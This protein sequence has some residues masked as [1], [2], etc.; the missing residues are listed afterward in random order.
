MPASKPQT[1][2]N[3][4]FPSRSLV[5]RFAG[6]ARQ[7]PWVLW[8]LLHYEFQGQLGWRLNRRVYPQKS[9][10]PSYLSISPT[11]RC[12]LKCRMCIQHR[13]G[14]GTPG[15]ITWYK[16]DQEL[17]L[18]AWV[19][20]FEELTTW[21]PVVFITGG[22]PLLYPHILEF[23]EG[24]KKR[25]LLVHLQTNG[26]LLEGMAPHLVSLG[27]EMVTVSLDGPAEVHNRI[28]GAGTFQRSAQGLQALKEARARQ[29][30]PGPILD[31]RCT[32]S[33]DNL[34]SLGRMAAV[35]QELGADM[36]QF[37]HTIFSTPELVARHNRLLSPAWAH[38]KGLEIIAPSIPE[39]EFYESQIGPGDL[40]L[41]AASLQELRQQAR[42]R[43][44]ITFSPNLPPDLLAPYYL[45]LAYPFPQACKSLWKNCRILPDGTVSPCL[46]L[47]MGKITNEPLRAVWN[48]P[49]MQR[50]RHLISRGLLPGCV[51]C[52]HRS[53]A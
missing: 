34:D 10:P 9:I 15:D 35:A 39:G 32:I 1:V 42:G 24:A 6:L 17:P 5:A 11:R 31:I 2:V 26:V 12:N 44:K 4:D 18:E 51:R 37:S 38:A 20:L 19:A 45:D 25:G 27:V 22:E 47:V 43:L 7:N 41:L 16:P 3:P 53:Y 29:G 46:H 33:R 40:P 8:S 30:R 52:C 48:G 23:M 13:H 21:R 28:R 49:R 50:L 36:L 14:P